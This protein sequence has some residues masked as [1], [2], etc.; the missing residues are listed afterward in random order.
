MK[1]SKDTKIFLHKLSVIALPIIIQELI[2][3]AVNITDTFMISSLGE[4]PITA[5]G[6][7]N[8]IFFL[9]ILFV[10][11]INSGASVFMGQFW[12]A[13]D[14]KSIHKTMG[15]AFISSQV[16]ATTFA[17]LAFFK[18]DLLIG[19]YSSDA[20][21]IDLGTQYLRVAC[22]TYFLSAF[23]FTLNTAQ[24]STG[25]TKYPMLTTLI[26]FFTN[27][28]LNYYFIFIAKEGVVGAAKGTLIARTVE[29]IAQIV[30]IRGLKLPIL[31]RMKNYIAFDKK[32]VAEFFKK[33]GPV[34]ANEMMWATGVTQYTRFYGQVGT[35]AQTSVQLANSMKQLFMVIGIGV[36][37][38]S[39]IILGNLLGANKI[40][41]AIRYAK[42]YIVTAGIL[43]TIMG[44]GLIIGSPF[45]VQLFSNI[46]PQVRDDTMKILIIISL[47]IPVLTF[48][49]MGVVGIL[50]SGGDT[51]VCLLIDALSVWLLGVPFTYLGIRMG[52]P[53]YLVVACSYMEEI[54]KFLFVVIR[55]RQRKWAQNITAS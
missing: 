25:H 15:I 46:S 47:L 1:F 12:G 55:V 26:A 34:I 10:F 30:I 51:F 11:G 23:S 19:Y 49:Y 31:G 22:F 20:V 33:A 7:A 45:I 13:K 32:F 16:V 3:S 17:T 41:K 35:E 43:S 18:A 27:I 36:G 42:K 8:Q 28:I 6:L 21:V 4:A 9:F 44:L 40:N 2:N 14:T 38:S 50:R 37:S 5:V 48:N 24:K 52:L 54:G 53:I 29:L 39:G